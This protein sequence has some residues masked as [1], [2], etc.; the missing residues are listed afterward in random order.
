LSLEVSR[1]IKL[2]RE[3][4]K[5]TIFGEAFNVSSVKTNKY[6]YSSATGN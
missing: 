2:P 5:F 4:M 3:G 6:N 1:D